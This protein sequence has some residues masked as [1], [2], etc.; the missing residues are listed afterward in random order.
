MGENDNR[1]GKGGKYLK[2]KNFPRRRRRTE[3][4]NIWRRKINGDA[5][6]PTNWL[7]ITKSPF[8]TTRQ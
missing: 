7:S 3:N 8:S 6:P 4:E 5:N 2:K 1:E